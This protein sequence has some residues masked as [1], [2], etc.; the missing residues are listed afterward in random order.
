MNALLG[1]KTSYEKA[2]LP[3]EAAETDRKIQDLRAQ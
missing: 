2:N 3:K 1:L